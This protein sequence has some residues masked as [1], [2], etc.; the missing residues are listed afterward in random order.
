ML[1]AT[2]TAI[3][4]ALGMRA[5]VTAKHCLPPSTERVPGAVI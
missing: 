5:R 1:G 4:S 3:T 2:P